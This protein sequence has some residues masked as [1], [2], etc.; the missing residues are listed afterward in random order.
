M[1]EV[2]PKV[3]VLMPV[4]NGGNYLT[5]AIDS[6]LNQTFTDF[7]LLIVNDGSTD[8]TQTI[9]DSYTDTRIK[10]LQQTNQG[11][12]QSLNN[13]LSAAIG[14]Y[15]WRHDADDI[16]LPEQLQTQLQFLETFPN[17]TLVSTQ[18]ALMSNH[19]KIAFGYKQPKDDYFKGK[20]Y[21]K[22]ERSQFNPYSPITHATVLVKKEVFDAV[23]VYRTEFKTSEDTD[24]WLRILERFNCAVLNYCPYFV[25][26]NPTSAT[27]V[28]K[29]TN[30]FY[31]DLAYQFADERA[32]KGTDILQRGEAMPKPIEEQR[33]D[34]LMKAN[35]KNFRGDLLRYHYKL[36][37]NAKD[38]KNVF[39]ILKISLK[40]GWRLASTWKAILLPL[41]GSKVL[42]K[43][44]EFKQKLK[45]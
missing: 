7:E 41:L 32:A 40:D 11:V 30:T 43:G 25:R 34:S 19:G 35:G 23:G 36:M 15:I 28:Y 4:Y 37:L 44:M 26:L 17:F 2:M 9:I 31:R 6:V 33:T 29:K 12:A 5:E 1:N 42:E 21:V 18:I 8:R 24:L 45:S 3:T 14:S 20:P 39:K 38:Y 16:S 27:Q 22:V 13:G 10:C